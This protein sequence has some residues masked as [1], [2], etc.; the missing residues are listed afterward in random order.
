MSKLIEIKRVY[1][2]IVGDLPR[3]EAAIAAENDPVCRNRAVVQLATLDQKLAA[4]RTWLTEG[5]WKGCAG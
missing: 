2:T 5:G 3:V 1:L 4:L